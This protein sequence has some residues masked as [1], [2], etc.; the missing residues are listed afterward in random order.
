MQS[1]GVTHWE[2]S[3]ICM[4]VY[5]TVYTSM[6]LLFEYNFIVHFPPVAW[7]KY[8][9]ISITNKPKSNACFNPAIVVF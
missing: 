3:K 7:N 5:Y 1:G 2:P 9:I 6:G 4:W 8:I